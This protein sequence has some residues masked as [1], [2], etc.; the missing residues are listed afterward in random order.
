[1]RG[2]GAVSIVDFSEEQ[3][4]FPVLFIPSYSVGAKGPLLLLGFLRG[5]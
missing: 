1:M 3:L 4:D 2:D 5:C